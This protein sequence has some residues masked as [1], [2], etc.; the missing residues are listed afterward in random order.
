MIYRPAIAH[1]F[2]LCAPIALHAQAA[3]ERARDMGIPLEGEPG[4]LNAIT[5]VPGVTVGHSTL[6]RGSG[7]LRVG[8]GPVRTGVTAV[9]P[10]GR[11]DL[12]EVFAGWFSLNGNGEMT[13]T[14]WIDDY[15]RM[16]YPF[17]LPIPTASAW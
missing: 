1:L 2:L 6:I 15:G 7:K 4:P 13:G 5:D 10:R 16:L 8:Q 12:S 17:R 3:A 9:F 11:S 14:P